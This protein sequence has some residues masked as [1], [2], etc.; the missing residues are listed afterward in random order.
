MDQSGKMPVL[1][2]P[3]SEITM[4]K[5]SLAALLVFSL[6]P[7]ASH[8]QYWQDSQ[9]ISLST[10]AVKF[11]G[12]AADRAALGYQSSLGLKYSPSP[13]F[14]FAL[15]G[16]Y[17]SFK[18][19]V[20]G[21]HYQKD[22]NSPYRTFLFPFTLG[23]RLTPSSRSVTKPYLTLGSGVLFWDLRYLSGE[24]KSFWQ[25]HLWRWGERVSGWRKNMLFYQGLGVEH[26]FNPGLSLDVQVRFSSL[27]HLHRDNTGQDD[28]NDQMMQ[29]TATLTWYWR[30]QRDRDKDGILDK[31]DA[32]PLKPEDFDHF[33]DQDGAPDL[34]ND[35]DGV[36]DGCDLAPLEPEDKDQFE[37]YD[38]VPDPD[39]DLDGIPDIKDQ[40]PS[41]AEDL[42][43]FEDADGCPDPDNDKDGILDASDKCLNQAED[44]D[45]FED[46][47]G[48]PDYDN[49]GDRIPD[50]VDKCPNQPETINGF[51]DEDGC[52]DADQDGDGIQDEL[53]HCPDQA[54]TINGFRDDD[55]CPDD[56][57]QLSQT[58]LS[59]AG[60]TV[61]QGV[62]FASG[63]AELV[64]ES[65]PALDEVANLLI[66]DPSAIIE[67]RGHTD[68]VGNSEKNQKL[69]ELRALAVRLYL[70]KK[71]ILSNRITAVGFGQRYPIASNQ[72]AEGRKQNRRIEFVRVQ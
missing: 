65:L 41:A 30:H 22:D 23:L 18:P 33:E 21:S 4:Q 9:G 6:M 29:A 55:G 57:Q 50:L 25:D 54:E 1:L 53:D 26:F 5:R 49:D 59:G 71:G 48:C 66:L 17:G 72:T 31:E 56:P 35:R 19:A 38:G 62:R 39:N 64:S 16:G 52:P 28:L 43:G 44:L 10:G 20:A 3:F 14:Q 12:D 60:A 47:D 27:L 34:D 15:S 24:K 58:E 51:S 69:S 8:A 61:L 45:G 11:L 2:N 67:I 36:L 32:D 7:L 46:D 40:C 37:D 13:F 42:D 68:N 63:K 70:I